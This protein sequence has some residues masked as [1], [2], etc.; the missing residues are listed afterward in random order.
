MF[1]APTDPFGQAYFII[2]GF[3]RQCQRDSRALGLLECAFAI[4][5]RPDALVTAMETNLL[6]SE[7]MESLQVCK[8]GPDFLQILAIINGELRR[9]QEPEEG[10]LGGHYSMSDQAE[11]GFQAGRMPGAPSARDLFRTPF[12]PDG[13]GAAAASSP[14]ESRGSSSLVAS[15][16]SP[17]RAFPDASG[18]GGSA[19]A[20]AAAPRF[21]NFFSLLGISVGEVSSISPK[22]YQAARRSALLKYHTDR[23]GGNTQT[24]QE[25]NRLHDEYMEFRR[26]A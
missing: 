21:S 13:S 5:N 16:L 24:I 3:L 17:H 12:G 8:R 4:L 7:L 20:A 15:P 18:G 25:L 1:S 14:T 2:M 9:L 6:S 19:P 11:A 23:P 10:S 26:W 22:Q